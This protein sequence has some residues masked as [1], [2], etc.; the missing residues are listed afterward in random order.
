MLKTEAVGRGFQHLP[1]D[2]ANVNVL[3]NNV[4]SLLLHKIND[5]FVK[6]WETIWHYI[7]SPFGRQRASAHFLNIRLPG[8]SVSRDSRWLP[9]FDSTYEM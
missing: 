6:I 2:L 7:L 3:E 9:S 8:P 1:R 5:L 4:R